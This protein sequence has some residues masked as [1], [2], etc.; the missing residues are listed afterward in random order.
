M[1]KPLTDILDIYRIASRENCALDDAARSLAKKNDADCSELL[2][3]C[4]RALNINKDTFSNFLESDNAFN[5]KN[6]LIRRF[7]AHQGHII[8]FFNSYEDTSDIPILDFTKIIKP[9]S[10]LEKKSFNSRVIWSSLKENFE[11]WIAR[12]DMPQDV[13][14]ELKGWIRRIE[15]HNS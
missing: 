11:D 14:D 12:N 3:S 10:P 8:K 2:S 9:L 7:P 15:D 6:F 5:F 4:M 13:K 1:N